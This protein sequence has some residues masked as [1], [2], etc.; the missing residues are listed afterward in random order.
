MEFPESSCHRLT[1]RRMSLLLAAVCLSLTTWLVMW[2]R[3]GSAHG[4]RAVP[5]C[6]VNFSVVGVCV[7]LGLSCGAD[8]RGKKNPGP[9]ESQPPAGPCSPGPGADGVV[10]SSSGEGG[11]SLHSN[12][13]VPPPQR[14][15]S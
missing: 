8:L 1:P 11:S 3:G 14:L 2:V 7:F 5:R 15:C 13:R 6:V 10:E 12:T 4:E 9:E